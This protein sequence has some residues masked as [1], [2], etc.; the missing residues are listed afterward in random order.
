M[1]SGVSRL[2][3]HAIQSRQVYEARVRANST[4]TLV[5]LQHW[6]SDDRGDDVYGIA[7]YS[8]RENHC[9]RVPGIPHLEIGIPRLCK[10]VAVDGKIYVLGGEKDG[11]LCGSEVFELDLGGQKKWKRCQDM[12]RPR[13]EFGLG[14]LDGKIYVCEGT[15]SEDDPVCGSE[16]YNPEEDIWS[17]IRS[18][19]SLRFN[20][21]VTALGGELFAFG[22]SL[23]GDKF[24]DWLASWKDGSGGGVKVYGHIHFARCLE[25]YNPDLDDWRVV[26]PFG[27][28]DDRRLFV[29]RGKFHLMTSSGV[30]VLDNGDVEKNGWTELHSFSPLAGIED[31]NQCPTLAIDGELVTVCDLPIPASGNMYKTCLLRSKGFGGKKKELVWEEANYPLLLEIPNSMCLIQL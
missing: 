23:Y 24:F 27:G 19:T 22:G 25:V 5:L 18:M 9:Y 8:M 12:R 17:S 14:V 7:L 21:H 15:T 16:V 3:Q 31:C 30:Y 4:E 28:Q 29:E 26:E 6:R 20:H 1:L 2:W 11:D 10:C 13:K